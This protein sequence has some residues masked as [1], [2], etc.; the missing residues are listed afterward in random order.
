MTA[1]TSVLPVNQS[2][3]PPTPGWLSLTMCCLVCQRDTSGMHL[4]LKYKQAQPLRMGEMGKRR[5]RKI[6][7]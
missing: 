2:Q 6:E 4:S 5:K 7:M 3:A 1:V